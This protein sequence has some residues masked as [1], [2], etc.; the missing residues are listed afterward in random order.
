MRPHGLRQCGDAWRKRPGAWCNCTGIARP[1]TGRRISAGQGWSLSIG[2][3][4]YDYAKK[5]SET[6]M[7]L[8]RPDGIVLWHD[9]GVWDGVARALEELEAARGL[10]LVNIRG[11][12][13]CLA[14]R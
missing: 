12:S 11:S 13:W 7:R 10:G 8:V 1:K 5:N 2:S 14:R 6:A 3:H 4:A 9:Y